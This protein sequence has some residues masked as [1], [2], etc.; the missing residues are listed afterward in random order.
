LIFPNR[1]VKQQALVSVN[2]VKSSKACGAAM[3]SFNGFDWTWLN[4]HPRSSS[5]LIYRKR[6]KIDVAGAATL[7]IS[8]KSVHTK[9]RKRFMKR[10][11]Q[12]V[13]ES[14]P[15]SLALYPKCWER[16]RSGIRQ[17]GSLRLKTWTPADST[18]AKGE[19]SS[20]ISTHVSGGWRIFMQRF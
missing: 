17:V 9:S 13:R 3:E 7:L 12:N 14:T 11:R 19:S 18:C 2:S 20:L 6:A 8:E 15:C 5:I 4:I 1:F 10:L 16:W